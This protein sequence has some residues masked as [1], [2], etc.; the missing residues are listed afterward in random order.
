[1][2][3]FIFASAEWVEAY[4]DAINGSAAYKSAAATWTYGVVALV[5]LAN[6]PSFPEARG[7]WLDLDRGVCRDAKLVSVEAAKKAPFCIT[8]EYARW[9]Q[10]VRKELDP[11]KGMMQ[12]KLK[13]KGDLPTVVRAVRASQELVNSSGSVETIFSDETA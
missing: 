6:P 10:V 12:G 1:M 7:I 8:G 2:M 4:K 13:L 11:I 3:G 9:K 5:V